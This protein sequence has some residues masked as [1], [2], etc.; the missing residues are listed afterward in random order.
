MFLGLDLGTTNIKATVADSNG[1]I[2]ARGSAPVKISHLPDG[3]VEQDIEDICE[4]T[5]S[6]IAQAGVEVN[7]SAVRAVG[8]SSQGGA[9]QMLDGDGQPLGPV[10]SWLDGRGQPHDEKLTRELGGEWFARHTG[11]GKSGVAAGQILR[12]REESPE[13]VQPPNRVGFVGD[14]IVSRLCGR[15]AHDATSLSIAMLYNP[16]LRRADPELL[17]KLDFDENQLPALIPVR[18]AAGGLLQDVAARTSL[19]AGIPVSPAVHDQYASA[20]GSCAVRAGDVMFGTG[21]AWVLLAAVARLAGPV[22]DSALVCT[23]VVEGLYG[24]M[25]SMVNGGSSFAW[26]TRLLGLDRKNAGELDALMKSAPPGSDELRF[27][28][29]LAAGGGAGLAPGTRGCLAGLRLSHS[30]AHVLRAVVEGLAMELARYIHFLVDNG[31]PVTRLVMCGG[32]AAS[33]V[34]PQIVADVT[35]LPV[36]CIKEKEVSAF[37]AVVIARGLVEPDAD[38]ATLCREMTPDSRILEPG[39]DSVRYRHLLD[40]YVASLPKARS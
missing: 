5:V 22:T 28:P 20:L 11:H 24:Q 36:A 29:L 27:R 7:L 14:I 31:T 9:L 1:R 13:Q 21:T 3:G 16:S 35:G 8:V 33:R 12:L 19:P 17:Q 37:G 6:A 18:S 25:L 15:R 32:A 4:A 38:L 26:A 30:P 23:H 10:I 34:T 39:P 40:E 2:R